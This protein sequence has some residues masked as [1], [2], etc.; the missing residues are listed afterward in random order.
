[1][2]AVVPVP[3]SP[4]R[5]WWDQRSAVAKVVVVLVGAIV[6][7]NAV[8]A[9]AN[10]VAGGQQPGGPSSS[11]YSTGSQGF[12]AWSQLLARRG[13]RVVKVR[14]PLADAR[15]PPGAT[16]V[17]ADPDS[18][19]ADEARRVSSVLAGG[20]RVVLLGGAAMPLATLAGGQVGVAAGRLTG[21]PR[22]GAEPGDRG[23]GARRGRRERAPRGSGLP[24]PRVGD[25]AR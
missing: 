8:V 18:L 13:H 9:L 20:G 19:G 21:G 22:A 10:L 14:G 3:P 16:L 2:S 1:M 7:V 17:I 23:P 6:A 4:A 5:A 24:A 12:A 15:L 25:R 11:A